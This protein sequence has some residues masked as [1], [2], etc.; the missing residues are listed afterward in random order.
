M[1]LTS[2]VLVLLSIALVG[3]LAY[4]IMKIPMM[5]PFQ[6]I[7][8]VAVIVLC[9]LYLLGIVTGTIAPPHYPFVEVRR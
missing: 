4:M 6:D 3:F 5:Q 9:V 8:Q 7:I 2:I 1:D